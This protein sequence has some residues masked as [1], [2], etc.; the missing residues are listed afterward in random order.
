MQ[1]CNHCY[2]EWDPQIS[3]L[4]MLS[5]FNTIASY[6]KV[7]ICILSC[8]HDEYRLFAALPSLAIHS[9]KVKNRSGPL[10]L[11]DAVAVSLFCLVMTG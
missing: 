4:P 3:L 8:F 1:Y 5:Q 6:I 7:K 9:V 11:C 2:N 10:F